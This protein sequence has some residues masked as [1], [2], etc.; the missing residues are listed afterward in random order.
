[1]KDGEQERGGRGRG[2][3]PQNGITGLSIHLRVSQTEE[4]G[5]GGGEESGNEAGQSHPCSSVQ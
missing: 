2:E 4:G 1:M 5:G 3:N